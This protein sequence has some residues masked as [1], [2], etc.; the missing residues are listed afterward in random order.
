[1]K[2]WDGQIV[3]GKICLEDREGFQA[4]IQKLNGR[5]IQITLEKLRVKRSN[6][7]NRWYWGCIVA[8]LAEH[9]GYEAEEMHEALK[10][11]FLRDRAD[12]E[13]GGL[14]KI[15]SS[16]N[17]DTAAFSEYCEKC[18]RLAAEMGIVIPLPDE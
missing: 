13:V 1:M 8:L 7:Q 2:I 14:P 15:R 6:P 5:H 18:V 11:R 3:N 10:A 12:E 9:C 4:L 16:A 17:L